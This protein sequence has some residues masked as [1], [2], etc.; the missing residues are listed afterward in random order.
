MSDQSDTEYELA[1]KS[2]SESI[3]LIQPGHNHKLTNGTLDCE[4]IDCTEKQLTEF[5]IELQSFVRE[6]LFNRYVLSLSELRRLYTLQMAS[7]PPGHILATG[8]TD[9]LLE[10]AVLRVGGTR[11]KNQ[12]IGLSK[13][14]L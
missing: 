11:V 4:I 10:E 2:N 5:D 7:C 12:V 1:P 14:K 8:V 9:Q 3:S 13:L 6:K